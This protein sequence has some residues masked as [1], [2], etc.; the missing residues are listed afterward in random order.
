MMLGRNAIPPAACLIAL[1]AL[2]GCGSYQQS[3]TAARGGYQ[4]TALHRQ[5]VQTV[6]VPIFTNTDFAR[7]DE[8]ALTKALVTQIEQRTPYKVVDR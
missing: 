3:G 6:A 7:G 8:F 1:C 2:A 5:D 4:W